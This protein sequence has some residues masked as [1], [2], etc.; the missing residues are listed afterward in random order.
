MSNPT[1]AQGAMAKV[2]RIA[3]A[4]PIVPLCANSLIFSVVVPAAMAEDLSKPHIGSIFIP[5]VLLLT[6]A[7]TV[8]VKTETARRLERTVCTMPAF[9]TPMIFGSILKKWTSVV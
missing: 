5:W 9:F 8:K 7:E 2:A 3:E 1:K 4:I 6:T